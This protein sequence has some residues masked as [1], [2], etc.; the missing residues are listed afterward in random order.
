MSMDTGRQAIAL[1]L[2]RT[3]KRLHLVF[4][5]GE[6][7]LRWRTLVALTHHAVDLAGESGIEVCPSVTTNGTLVT[8]ARARWLAER[9]FVTAVSCDGNA[10]AHDANRVDAEGNGSHARTV[11]GIRTALDAGLRVRV[12]LVLDP[13]N[14]ALLPES[15]AALQDLGVRDFVINP[16]WS[17]AWEDGALR[18]AWERAYEQLG[19]LYV[20]AWRKGAPLWVSSIDTKIASHIKGGYLDS[21]RCDLGRRDL[22]VAPSGNL[23]PC[24]R[25]VGEDRDGRWVIGHVT[26][27]ADASKVG[28]VAGPARTL[29]AE[30]LTCAIAKRCRNRC[31]CANLAMTGALSEPSDTLCFHE[32]LSIRVADDAAERLFAEGNEAFIR[33]H[34]RSTV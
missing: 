6:P 30:C 2:P 15:V 7:M 3:S 26:T 10:A 18:G 11:A 29:P 21:E 31:A 4:F 17:A 22:V 9:A 23:Y 5:G 27:G 19:E 14:V 12:I 13:G 25:M 24:D 8:R 33:R 32:Q 16:N 1:A 28:C 34:Y 20:E